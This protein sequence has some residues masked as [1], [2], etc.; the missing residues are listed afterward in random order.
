[1]CIR[2]FCTQTSLASS[3]VP[4]LRVQAEEC[5]PHSW[6]DDALLGPRTPG[7]VQ[8]LRWQGMQQVWAVA[9][10]ATVPVACGRP[11]RSLEMQPPKH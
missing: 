6:G 8:R 9:A 5:S 10:T 4:R 2:Y 1:M 3:Q 7:G 11:A